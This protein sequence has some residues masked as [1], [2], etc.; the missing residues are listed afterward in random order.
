MSKAFISILG[1]NDYLE[2]FHHIDKRQISN[3]PSKYVQEDLIKHF[4]KDWQSDSEVRI[5]LTD[6]ARERNWKDN[7]HYDR[8]NSKQKENIGLE[9]RLKKLNYNLTIKDISIPPGNNEKELWQIFEIIFN[10]FKEKDELIIDITHSFRFLP[11]LLT[12]MLN[13]TRQIKNIKINGVYYAA[14]ETLGPINEVLQWK[15]ED[16]K[17]PIFD[18][19]SLVKLQEWTLATYDYTANANIKSLNKLVRDEIKT[20]L[21]NAKSLGQSEILLRETI[22]LLEQVS[23][24]ISLCR[25]NDIMKF[26]YIELLTNLKKLKE[27][28]LIIKPIKML[29][30]VIEK[31]I[32]KFSDDDI[33][34]G[35]AAVKWALDHKLYQQAITIL[36][37]VIITKILNDLGL[38]PSELVNRE[39]V[40]GAI[41]I[42]S[43]NI[44]EDKWHKK[45]ADNKP[46]TKKILNHLFVD[47]IK[48]NFEKL[49][50]IR[51]DVNHAG[52]IETHK[53]YT[54][55]IAKLNNIYKDILNNLE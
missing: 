14:F 3:T 20:I 15:I 54:S 7:G 21:Y 30:D 33:T 2:S 44:K 22:P 24:N 32:N 10:T 28:D 34:N 19:T 8:K 52:F 9:N 13:Y 23:L 37:E 16:R 53:N 5:F 48:G 50:S 45:N 29:I 11:M 49:T 51:N 38:D 17:T 12:V 40:S 1:T 31:K 27:S 36:Q 55:I 25:G 46:L 39:I 6:E 47:K 35:I 18:V 41:K 42:K 26:N 4:C 43:Q